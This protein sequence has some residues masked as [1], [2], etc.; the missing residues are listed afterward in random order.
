MVLYS[1]YTEP[2]YKTMVFYSAPFY[3]YLKAIFRIEALVLCS[4]KT[5][6][7]G[8]LLTKLIVTYQKN[9]RMLIQNNIFTHEI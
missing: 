1:G 2:D 5:G 4:G 6:I 8:D 9:S 3:V 7:Y